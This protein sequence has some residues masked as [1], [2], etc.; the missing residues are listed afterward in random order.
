[1]TTRSER[2]NRL[3]IGSPCS[4]S[5][6]AMAGEGPRRFCDACGREVYDVAQMSPAGIH[7]ELHASRGRMCARL[8][9]QGGRLIT[10][11]QVE[12]AA[13]PAPPRGRIAA[14]AATLVTAWLAAANAEGQRG[15]PAAAVEAAAEP[16]AD[17]SPARHADADVSGALAGRV[18]DGEG[19]PVAGLQMT[20][21]NALDG[22]EHGEVTAGDGTFQLDAL[23]AGMYD[24]TGYGDEHEVDFRAGIVVQ[25]GERQR[26]ELT[27]QPIV[28]LAGAMAMA[29]PPLR[30]RFG[31]SDLVVAA[32]IG[33]SS[34]VE[35]R[36]HRLTVLTELRVDTVFKG[37]LGGRTLVQRHW[38]HD[39]DGAAW[40]GEYAPG[41]RVVA[42]LDRGEEAAGSA[43][44]PVFEAAD[45]SV[46]ISRF[47]DDAERTAYE[48]RLEALARIE[49]RAE[50]RG[51]KDP[52]ELVEW[53]VATVEEPLTRSEAV[54]ELAGA[55]AALAERAAATNA[56]TDVAAADLRL[57]V[58]RFRDG[59][60]RLSADPRPALLGAALTLDH[61]QRL[62][63]ALAATDELS[64][65]AFELF[66][67][68][69]RWD[70]GL[71]REWLVSRLA[72]AESRADAEGPP[73]WLLQWAESQDDPELQALAAEALERES[74]VEAL[75]P[76]DESAPTTELRQERGVELRRELRQRFAEALGGGG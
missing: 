68:A 10:A 7:A 35:R 33:P 74:A 44:R 18:V 16:E 8:T 12:P 51:E 58:E 30:Q 75:W 76:G 15:A 62:G 54:G 1:M 56:S 66:E 50:R 61:R 4:A 40:A 34:V 9:R 31:N 11:P 41:T 37:T 43:G 17:P 64:H 48:A 3:V 60:G 22:S 53:L 36:E 45:Y 27:A 14:V 2:L 19:A 42:F 71:A 6:E 38:E 23:P 24:L 5:W 57:L 20:A 65:D 28:H 69:S 13:T 21:R 29:A 32:V 52:D 47:G 59:G 49:R 63:A 25:P 39:F 55:V 70:G 26:V 46:G 73:W 72:A 67:L